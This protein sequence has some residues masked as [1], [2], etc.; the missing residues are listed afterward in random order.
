[1][2]LIIGN[3]Y[4]VRRTNN[5]IV[6]GTLVRT[7]GNDDHYPTFE[8]A[9]GLLGVHRDNVLGPANDDAPNEGIPRIYEGQSGG[10]VELVSEETAIIDMDSTGKH[11]H[12][13]AAPDMEA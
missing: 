3:R 1:M 2:E 7:K 5:E 13:Q 10:S 4:R 11:I 9:S 6:E 8:T 12:Y